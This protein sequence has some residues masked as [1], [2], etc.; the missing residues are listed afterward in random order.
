MAKRLAWLLLHASALW[1]VLPA[2]ADERILDYH[3]DIV[4]RADASVEVHET[5]RVR[6]EGQRIKHGIFRDFPTLYRDNMGLRHSV[7]FNLLQAKM[8]GSEAESYS[9]E[10]LSNGVRVKIGDPELELSP[11]EHTFELVYTATRELGFF[12]D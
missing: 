9:I 10:G 6:S 8:S 7:E 12:A 5:I 2:R 1:L 4:V 3:A 11:G